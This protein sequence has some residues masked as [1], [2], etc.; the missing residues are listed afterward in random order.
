MSKSDDDGL[1]FCIRSHKVFN[2]KRFGEMWVRYL[3]GFSDRRVL[4]ALNI[5]TSLLGDVGSHIAEKEVI[6]G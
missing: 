3:P 6:T 4:S 1:S 5:L 2:S